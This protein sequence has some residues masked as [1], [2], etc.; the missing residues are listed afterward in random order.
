MSRLVPVKDCAGKGYFAQ[1][2]AATLVERLLADK[3]SEHTK[4]AYAK[5]LKDFFRTTTGR[6]PTAQMVTAFL[7]LERA[8]AKSVVLDYKAKL[9]ERGLSEAT[10][11]RRLSLFCHSRQQKIGTRAFEEVWELRHESNS[12]AQSVVKIPK[13]EPELERL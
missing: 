13:I 8:E 5:D 11:N 4:K 6:E 12:S 3:R 7:G 1:P 9:I 2:S 10:V